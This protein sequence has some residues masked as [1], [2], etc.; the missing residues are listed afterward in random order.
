MSNTTPDAIFWPDNSLDYEYSTHLAM[1]AGSMQ[2]ALIKRSWY[3]IGTDAQRLALGGAELRDG[4]IFED[5]ATGEVWQRKGGAWVTKDF[6]RNLGRIAPVTSGVQS[7]ITTSWTKISGTDITL[8]LASP[9]LLR[10][11]ASF[12]TDSTTTADAAYV[13]IMDGGTAIYHTVVQA[14]S[15]PTAAPSARTQN[16]VTDLVLPAGAHNFS[17]RI[18]RAVGSG[19][20]RVT[21]GA[22]YPTTFSIDRIG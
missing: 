9:T 21:P 19:S 5:V 12:V 3:Y 13:D 18:V 15:S 4:I 6:V 14:N 7:G 22:T 17:V 10:F 1:M 2:S 16:I 8:S 11:Y 20:I